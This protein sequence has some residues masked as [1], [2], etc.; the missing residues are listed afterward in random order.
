[1]VYLKNE[2]FFPKDAH[3]L[4]SEA[5][6]LL[7]GSDIIIRDVRVSRDHLEYDISLGKSENVEKIEDKLSNIG[8]LIEL[9][10]VVEIE[11]VKIDAIQIAKKFF[12]SE[13]YWNAH[14]VLEGVWKKSAGEEKKLLNGL[15]LIAAALVHYQKD[16]TSICLGI[17]QRALEKIANA[18]GEYFDID[19]DSVR[20]KI[21]DIL[22][23]GKVRIFTI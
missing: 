10:N 6:R 22:E 23:S 5:R 16:E 7:L 17:M 20:G 3:Y 15:I 21:K 2:K 4:L 18:K 9:Y 8:K 14:E 13:K 19:I 1:M 12:N 11:F